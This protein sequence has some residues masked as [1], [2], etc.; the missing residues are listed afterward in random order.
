MCFHIT[1][2]A[3]N[4]RKRPRKVQGQQMWPASFHILSLFPDHTK[5]SKRP[6]QYPGFVSTLLKEVKLFDYLGLRL[7]PMM[8]MKV[9]AASILAKANKGHSLALAVSYSLRYDKHHSIPTFCSSPVQMLNLWKSCV[10]RHFLLYLR[11][12]SDASQVQTLQAT[13]NRSL[14]TTLHVYGHPTAL[15][16]DTEITPLYI[17]QNLQLAQFRFR[18]HSS[19][20][21][22]IQH[23]LW[24]LWQ[25]LLQVVPLNTLKYRMQTTI[26]HVDI[27][28]RDLA[29]PLPQKITLAKS[30]NKEKSYKKYLESRCSD[31]W[32]K[33]LELTLRQDECKH[34]YTGICTTNTNAACLNQPH[35]SLINLAL[36]SHGNQ[37]PTRTYS[38]PWLEEHQQQEY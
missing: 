38:R 12:I 29:S 23:S 15:L 26:C 32:R 7:D 1:T 27:A 20:L 24:Q 25:P 16:A 22:T 17:T 11:Y 28:R 37:L 30:L 13:L 2:Q 10:L 31:Q 5:P 14:S 36:E 18:L 34:T 19:P 21:D 4:A 35:I 8:T 9:A 3:R 6:H 33:H